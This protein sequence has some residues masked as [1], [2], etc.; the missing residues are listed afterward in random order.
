MRP[1][2]RSLGSNRKNPLAVSGGVGALQDSDT[3][4]EVIH[5][6]NSA[7]QSERLDERRVTAKI[8]DLRLN[9]CRFIFLH[10]VPLTVKFD[11]AAR[12]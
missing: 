1:K 7:A 3:G 10:G 5:A 12:G 2:A 8:S 9:I 6:V 11:A 4:K